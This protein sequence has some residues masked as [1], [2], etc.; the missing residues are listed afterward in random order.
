MS[1]DSKT[2]PP[3]SGLG[4]FALSDLL[5]DISPVYIPDDI[6]TLC[7][8][9]SRSVQAGMPENASQAAALPFEELLAEDSVLDS[10]LYLGFGGMDDDIGGA[11]D[12]PLLDLAGPDPFSSQ[13]HVLVRITSLADYPEFDDNALLHQMII[14]HS[15]G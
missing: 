6:S 13:D 5:E 8:P 4:S 12:S 11:M 14:M 2:A 10:L 15:N 3:A 9:Q 1:N 7:N